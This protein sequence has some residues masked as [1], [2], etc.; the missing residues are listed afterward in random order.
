MQSQK[1]TAQLKT[2]TNKQLK[3]ISGGTGV[4]LQK[5]PTPL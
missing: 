4:K 2:L 3:Q 5:P 1:S